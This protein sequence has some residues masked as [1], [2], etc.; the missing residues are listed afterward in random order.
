MFLQVVSIYVVSDS[1]LT[2]GGSLTRLALGIPTRNRPEKLRT[3]LNSI[4]KMSCSPSVIFVCDSSDSAQHELVTN[5]CIESVIPT[6]LIRSDRA[7][8][9]Y[10]RNRI[11]EFALN[12]EDDF[13]FLLFLDD[14]TEPD[15]LYSQ[16]L[17][18]F[19]IAH[20]NYGGACGVTQMEKRSRVA[21]WFGS[22]FLVSGRPGSVL[23]SGVGVPPNRKLTDGSDTHWIF[24]CSM[25]R[26]SVLVET[27]W[28]ECWEGYAAGEDVYFSFSVNKS[29]KLRVLPLAKIVNFYA[30]EGRPNSL[31]LTRMMVNHRWE[32]AQ[33]HNRN[34]VF[35][36][37]CVVWSVIGEMGFCLLNA[38]MKLDRSQRNAVKGYILGLVDILH[39]SEPYRN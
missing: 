32:I 33:L 22:M 10:Q 5:I 30:E 13:G 2:L 1:A 36:L 15:Y 19:L 17:L 34:R 31:Q 21:D 38:A 29:W 14:D 3:T 39:F 37:T 11:V 4:S 7:S 8:I 9:P 23:Y 27:K 26:R 20:P 28:N 16:L 12:S 25:W 24:G 35:L 6:V 18:E